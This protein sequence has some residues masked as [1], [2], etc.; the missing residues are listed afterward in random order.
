LADQL[1]D[2]AAGIIKQQ[3]GR[4]LVVIDF[5]A[6]HAPLAA[7]LGDFERRARQLETALGQ[8]VFAKHLDLD[9]GH[10]ALR[11]SI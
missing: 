7:S 1:H 8:Q 9:L 11:S 5:M 4:V 2:A 3:R 6:K 10:A